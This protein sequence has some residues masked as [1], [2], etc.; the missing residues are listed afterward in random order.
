MIAHE[1]WQIIALNSVSF[2]FPW[3]KFTILDVIFPSLS[4]FIIFFSSINFRWIA[5]ARNIQRSFK[6]RQI[7]ARRWGMPQTPEIDKRVGLCDIHTFF[8]AATSKAKQV[9]NMYAAKKRITNCGWQD[10]SVANFHSNILDIRKKLKD[11]RRSCYVQGIFRYWGWNFK[12]QDRINSMTVY[13]CFSPSRVIL[14]LS[15]H[16]QSKIIASEATGGF[17]INDGI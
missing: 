17:V 1:Y 5:F 16:L 11:H 10:D 3:R 13:F 7:S 12:W 4:L 2:I 8:F 6:A 15:K 14:P 9:F